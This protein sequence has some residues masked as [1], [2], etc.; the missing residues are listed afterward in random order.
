[1]ERF[2]GGVKIEKGVCEKSSIGRRRH[3][4]R[5]YKTNKRKKERKANK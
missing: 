2:T 4:E 3:R 5:K 1:M